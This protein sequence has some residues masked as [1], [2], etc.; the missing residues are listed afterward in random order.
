MTVT[1]GGLDINNNM[2][3]GGLESASLVSVEQRWTVEGNSVIRTKPLNGGR[4]LTLG[5]Q[6]KSGSI[7]GIWC[8]RDILLIQDLE[9]AGQ[10]VELD[11]RGDVYNVIIASTAFRPLHQ[12]ELESADKKFLGT[13]SLIEG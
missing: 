3:L 11:Y 13:L 8:L 5:S 12:F 10:S 2:Y 1:L 9:Q 6:N 4:S 7:Q